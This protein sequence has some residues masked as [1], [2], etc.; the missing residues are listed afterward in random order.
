M[1]NEICASLFRGHNWQF[2]S[3]SG[4]GAVVEPMGEAAK[5]GQAQ[6]ESRP[7]RRPKVESLS[8]GGCNREQDGV[9]GFENVFFVVRM[10][11]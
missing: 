5:K 6:I 4:T 9:R 11:L 1:D 10:V 3:G 2:G 7:R 8:L